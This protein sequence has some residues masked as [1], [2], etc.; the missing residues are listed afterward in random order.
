MERDEQ[1]RQRPP[2]PEPLKEKASEPELGR[3]THQGRE[4]TRGQRQHP[5]YE[6]QRAS[7]PEPG[8][9]PGLERE[10]QQEW[11]KEPGQMLGLECQPGQEKEW[12]KEQGQSLGLDREPGQEKEWEKALGQPPGLWR[13]PGQGDEPEEAQRRQY[14]RGAEQ[15]PGPRE[16]STPGRRTRLEDAWP[17]PGFATPEPP[18]P[19][20]QPYRPP[21]T[22]PFR[23]SLADEPE[24]I[25]EDQPPRPRAPRPEWAPTAQPPR[26]PV[27]RRS[28]IV[29]PL[30]LILLGLFLLA[31][32][33]GF[34][35]WSI[36]EA[37][38]RLWPVCLIALGL[39]MLL[40]RRSSWGR[41]A[42]VLLTVA[43]VAVALMV[44]RPLR[45]ETP[46]LPAEPAQPVQQV[47]SGAEQVISRPLGEATEAQVVIHSQISVLTVGGGNLGDRLVQGTVVPLTNESITE[48]Y[49]VDG[50]VAYSE[51]RSTVHGPLDS[52]HG[53]GRWDLQLSDAVPINLRVDTG[54]AE[55]AI[56]L[57][58]LQV[59]Q[60]DVHAGLGDVKLT[61][62]AQ[63][64]VTGRIDAG[65]G[66]IVI[67]VPA[68][69]AARIRV[70]TGIGH[71]AATADFRRQDGYFVTGDLQEAE[72]II[73]LMVSG[74]IGQIRLETVD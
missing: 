60:L 29:G 18:I 52:Q 36:W 3:A 64:A 61:L 63:G 55:S 25:R 24:I 28:S 4:R 71:I 31:Q 15:E 6:L 59:P 57:S 43:A 67:R 39:D 44:A 35:D 20:V 50:S 45:V 42:A 16:E 22:T 40:G 11:D 51:L 5:T 2:E 27:R 30:L 48:E 26:A 14:E 1:D 10:P 37:L 69:R 54:V 19:P 46:A 62:P 70:A 8:Q 53:Q 32:S 41:T 34:I 73:D 21:H 33:L 38:W 23:T 58:R 9:L 74:G 49:H 56:D 47:Q 65:V 66:Q 7:E 12:D 68:N 17:E 13:E 72:E